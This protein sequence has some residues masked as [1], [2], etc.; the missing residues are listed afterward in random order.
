MDR[1]SIEA[2][3]LLTTAFAFLLASVCPPSVLAQQD[4]GGDDGEPENEDLPL[5]VDRRVPIDLT[6]GSWISLDVSPD[7]QT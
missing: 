1:R 2:R 6:E 5:E 7:G 4:G 3:H